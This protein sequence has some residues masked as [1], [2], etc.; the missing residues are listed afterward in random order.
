MP[1]THDQC[2]MGL[3]LGVLK[4]LAGMLAL[5]WC[6]ATAFARLASIWSPSNSNRP[7]FVAN[8]SSHSRSSLVGSGF[9]RRVLAGEG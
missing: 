1:L 3:M 7:T 8:T 2:G 6:P 9:R 5:S 4:C